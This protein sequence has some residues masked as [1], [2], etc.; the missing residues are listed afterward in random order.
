MEW[1]TILQP[2][3]YLV[4]ILYFLSVFA[5][6]W[7]ASYKSR[8]FP[9]LFLAGKT[10]R[11]YNVGL[12]IFGTNVN[13]SF[14]IASAGIGYGAGI[15]AAN[16]EWFAFLYIILLGM[17]FAPHYLNIK[18]STTPEFTKRRFGKSTYN[19]FSWYTLFTTV[20]IWLSF[21]LYTGS[22]LFSQI[23]NL[24]LWISVIFLTNLCSTSSRR[25]ISSK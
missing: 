7:Y 5:W 18:I 23:F 19:L 12:S 10:I 2:A 25:L 8:K 1:K 24:P 14:L 6:G 13:P 15:A 3:D 17:V 11:W 16:F 4:V 20:A 22:L 21:T 9:T